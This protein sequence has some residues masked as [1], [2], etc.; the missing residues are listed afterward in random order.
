MKI[1]DM[2]AIRSTL[3]CALAMSLLHGQAQAAQ[4]L[5]RQYN[6]ARTGANLHET[7]LT[8]QAVGGGRFQKLFDLQVDEKVEA[9]P[10]VVTNVPIA[11]QG[12]HDVVYIATM[13]NTVYAFDTHSGQQLWKS[14]QIGKPVPDSPSFDMWQTNSMWGILSTPVIDPAAFTMYFVTWNVEGGGTVYRLHA[15]DIRTG[16]ETLTWKS[17]NTGEVFPRSILI[18]ASVPSKDQHGNP[19]VLTFDPD[20]E[21]QRPALLLVHSTASGRPAKLLYIAFGANGEDIDSRGPLFN[22]HGWVFAYDVSKLGLP[23]AQIQPAVWCSTRFGGDGG[24]WQAGSGIAADEAGNVYALTGN[25]DFDNEYDL[26]ESFVKLAY[27]PAQGSNG[28][29]SLSAVDW[30]TPF[31]DKDRKND[32]DHQDR[33]LGSA[34]PTLLPDLGLIAGG[35]KDGI[36]Y[37][38]KP[39]AMGNDH[40]QAPANL[41]QPPFVA[42]YTPAP[43]VDPVKNLDAPMPDGKTHHIHGAPVYWHPAGIGPTLYLQGENE[44][45]RAFR[46]ENGSFRLVAMADPSTRASF[47]LPPPG[48]MPGGFLSLSANGTDGDSGVVWVT[49]P[50]NGDANMGKI[51]DGTAWVY[52]PDHVVLGVLRAYAATNFDTTHTDAATGVPELRL[53]FD[54]QANAARDSY[55]GFS[56][57]CPPTVANGEVFVPTFWFKVSVYG[58]K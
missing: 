1:V 35:G 57:F 45:L 58:L 18:T 12:V 15:M 19:A 27:R 44:M 33:D 26:S 16:L 21:K 24:L 40:G 31:Q 32:A 41:L 4:V 43:G 49:T 8:P 50:L 10:L 39:S 54:S 48:G 52:A 56:K 23:D 20:R 22:S 17:P 51:F 3:C 34:G 5:T 46:L 36:L 14:A 6:N 13:N 2:H 42:S 9:Q 30:Y 28:T 55:G 53:L 25:G 11:N 7:V 47:G 37:I 29:P 38:V